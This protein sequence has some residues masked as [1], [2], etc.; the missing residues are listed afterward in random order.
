VEKYG[1]TR[2]FLSCLSRDPVVVHKVKAH[3][4][5]R[6]QTKEWDGADVGIWFAD[7]IASGKNSEMMG[8]IEAGQVLKGVRENGRLLIAGDEGIAR[9]LKV[10]RIVSDKRLEEYLKGRD[11]GR[12]A[13][14]RR[15]KWEGLSFRRGAALM[16]RRKGVEETAIVMRILYDKRW[17]WN[18]G[19]WAGRGE[20]C[21]C[22]DPDGS[23]KHILFECENPKVVELRGKWRNEVKAR[24][25]KMGVKDWRGLLSKEIEA[26][27]YGGEAGEM[28]CCG[29]VSEE[30]AR[31]LSHA[32]RLVRDG[33]M[34]VVEKV[35]KE[36]FLGARGM[37]ALRPQR[38]NLVVE[39]PVFPV[40]RQKRITD[41]FGKETVKRARLCETVAVRESEGDVGS[42]AN[43]IKAPQRVKRSR[44]EEGDPG[45][46]LRSCVEGNKVYWEFKAG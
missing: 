5:R 30:W 2:E 21:H 26:C 40:L 14:G 3:P 20:C 42:K 33:E 29:A 6:K 15:A 7:W 31:S 44:G 12:L 23:R 13:G 41:F 25:E 35:L 39:G 8:E 36:V 37:L 43:D 28:L 19:K 9:R 34:R 45:K 10:S 22:S 18:K 4:E 27:C 32:N 38:G 11:E 46:R 24:T 17:D 16:R 1:E